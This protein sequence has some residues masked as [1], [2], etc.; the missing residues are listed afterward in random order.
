[1]SSVAPVRPTR[2]SARLAGKPLSEN[3]ENELDLPGKNKI[4]DGEEQRVFTCEEFFASQPDIVKNAI[5]VD[6]HYHGW[7]SQRIMD[8]YNI[9]G[10]ASE[11]WE[12]NGGGQFSFKSG[13]SISKVGKPAGWSDAKYVAFKMF[14]KNPNQ[15]FYR[16]T[17]PG[18]AQWTGDWSQEEQDLF[19][20]T[21]RQY[22]CGDKWGFF[23]S[24]IPNR[25]GYQ[26]SN[27][28]R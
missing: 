24:H 25:V 15:Y 17:E 26:C 4:I 18:M 28:Y 16:H 27:Y 6:G 5:R 13:E 22:G 10:S 20:E 7:L 9:A 1:M 14:R 8:T 11:A 12:S 19:L 3:Q 23:A 2:A 21:V